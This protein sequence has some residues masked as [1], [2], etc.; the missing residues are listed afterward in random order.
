MAYDLKPFVIN[1]S[2]LLYLLQQVN[3]V[4]LFDGPANSNAI[5]NFDRLSMDAYDAKGN[6]VWDHD[7]QTGSY[8]G[9]PLTAANVGLLGQG[10][11]QVSSPIGIRDVSG[12]HNNLFGD[13]AFWG[14]VD[15][16]FRR[17]ISADFTSYVTTTGADYT[18]GNSVIDY[19]PR[20]IS[21]TITTA[22]VHLLQDSDGHYVNWEA[23]RYASDST[24]A[25][26]ID[27]SAVNPSQLV[28]GAKIVAPLNTDI[29]V[30]DGNGN[31]LVWH[32]SDYQAS[33]VYTTTLAVLAATSYGGLKDSGGGAL[34]EGEAIWYRPIPGGALVSTGQT[35]QPD[36]LAYK[37]LIDAN[38]EFA[39][40]LPPEGTAIVTTVSESG[41]GL[42]ETLGHIDFQNPTS[43][44]FFIGSENP[45]VAPVNSWFGIFGQFFDHGLDLI[46]KGGNGKI[47]I[48]LETTDP[49][50]GMIG[51]DGQPTTS[52]TISRA[53]IAGLDANGDPNYVNHTSPFIDQSQTY[54]SVDQIT[55]LLREW[56]S[57]DDGSTY[58]AGMELFDGTTLV[59][60]WDRR[61]PDG[62]V[63]AVHDTLPTLNELRQHVLDTGRA[64]LNWADVLDYRNRDA[65]GQLADA[66]SDTAGV[67]IS[68][69]GHALILDMN[70]HFDAAH[71]PLAH[72]EAL[73]SALTAA[74]FP[75]FTSTSLS[76]GGL[77]GAGLIN[78]STNLINTNF[79]SYLPAPIGGSAIPKDLQDAVNDVMLDSVGDHYIAG[80]GRVN[81]NFGLTSIHHVFHEEHNYQVEN[82][83]NWIYQHDANNSPLTHDGLR[84]WQVDT[85]TSDAAGNYLN[86]DGSVA[87]DA[88]KMFNATKLLVEMEYQHAAVDQYARTVTPRIQEFVGYST[89]VDST[90][91][92]EYAQVAFRFGHST[93]RE[94]IDTIDPSGWM[95]GNV[96]RYAL[97]KAFLNPQVFA[98]EGVAAITLGLSRQQMSEVDEFITP[99]LNQGLLGQPLDLAAI[100]IAR[101]RDLGIPTLNDF[102]EGISLARYTSWDDFGKNMIH[103]E[104]L[105]NF[106]AAYSFGGDVAK[107]NAILGLFEGTL[108]DGDVAALG[109][110]AADALAFM[111]NNPTTDGGLDAARDGFNHIDS[112][113][114]GLAEAHVPGGLLGETFDAVFVAQI[115]SLMDGDRFYYLYRLFGTN[116]HEEVNNGQFKD[117]V[118]RNTGLS[119]LNGSIFA[120][121]DKYYEF[122]RAA[123]GTLN[124]SG[125]DL[126]EHLYHDT[127]LANPTLGVYSDGGASTDPNGSL[128]SITGSDFVRADVTNSYVRDVRPELDPTQVHTVE[129]TPTSGADSHEVIVATDNADFIHARSGDDTVYGEGGDDFIYGDGGVD[130]LYGGAGNDMIDTGEGPDLADGGAGKDIIYGRGSGSEVGGFDQLV[131]GTGNDLIIGGEGIDKLSGGNGDDIIYGD[132]LTN[133]EMGNTDPFT[134]GGDGNDYIDTGASGDLLYGEEGDDYLVGGIDQDLMQGGTGDDI[135]RPGSPS[136]AIN[137]GPDEVIGDDGFTNTGFDL[138]DFS[139]YAANAPGVVINF[140]TQNNPL[141]AIDGTTPFPAWWQI[142][143]A[144]GSQNNDVF[145]G[146]SSTA[147]A[148][149]DPVNGIT[150]GSNWLIG[151]SGNDTFTGAGGDDLIVGGSVRLDQLIGKYA[152]AIGGN[153]VL[154][155][156]AWLADSMQTTIGGAGYDNNAESAYSGASNRA[157]GALDTSGLLSAANMNSLAHFVEMLRSRMFRDLV[158]GD[159]GTDGGDTV[160]FSGRAS[161]YAI[162]DIVSANGLTGLK[163]ADS[164]LD[165]DGTDLITGVESLSFNTAV[166]ASVVENATLVGAVARLGAVSDT[167][168]YALSGADK[169]LFVV[170]LAGNLQFVLGPDFETPA[171][172]GTNNV[173]N[174]TVSARND[175]NGIAV[176]QGYDVT[177]TDFNEPPQFD[178][179]TTTAFIVNENT[180]QVAAAF[181]ATDP[182]GTNVTFALG[183]AD[184]LLFTINPATGEL[185]F[186][187][188]PDFENG[189]NSYS[190]TII[191]SDGTNLTSLPITVTVADV[192][193]PPTIT[194]S[195]AVSVFEN[196]QDATSVVAS[197]PEGAVVTY[198]ISGGVDAALFS[199]DVTT[200]LI[201]FANPLGADF[202]TPADVG[203]NNTYDIE[204]TVSDGTNTV[205]QPLQIAVTNVNEAPTLVLSSSTVAVNENSQASEVL[206]TATAADPEGTAVAF[207]LTGADA[208]LFNISPT[209]QLT[210]NASPNF[211]Q[212][213]DVGGDNTYD[214]SIVATDAGGLIATRAVS[215]TVNNVNE[216]PSISSPVAIS[217]AENTQLVAAVTGSDPDSATTLA[218]SIIG[219]ADQ[220]KFAINAATGALSFASAAGANFEAP[221]DAGANN[222]YDLVVQVSDGTLVASQTMAVTVIN[223]QEGVS[224]APVISDITP[225]EGQTLSLNTAGIADPDGLGALSYQWQS[226]DGSNW[227]DI[228]GATA[229]AFTPQD[230][231]GAALGFQAGLQLRAVVSYTDG[232]GLLTTINSVATGP[233]GVNWNAIAVLA[234]NFA[235]TAGDDIATGGLG[236]NTLNGG[237]GDDTLVYSVSTLGIVTSGRDTFDGGTNTA[238][239]DRFVLNGTTVAETFRIFTRAAAVAAGLAVPNTATEI[240]ITRNGNFAGA[241]L[242]GA[243]VLAELD[244]IEEITVNTLDVSANDGNGTPNGGASGGDTIAIFGN[245]TAPNTSLN[246]STITINGS[247]AGDTVDISGLTSEH[248]IVFN[249]S[250]AGGNVIGTLRPQD[251]VSE[252]V[253][254]LPP[255]TVINPPPAA[256]TLNG[257]HRND[258]LNGQDGDDT[259]NGNGGND[260][261]H[262]GKGADKVNGGDGQDKVYGDDGNDIINGG[263]GDDRG[264]GGAGDD[265]FKTTRNDGEDAYYGGSAS[266]DAGN[267]TLDMSSILTNISVNL[268]SGSNSKGY[269]QTAGVKDIL[270]GIENFAS[271]SGNDTII[272]STA[273]NVMDGGAGKDTFVFKSAAHA[274][275][276]TISSFEAGDRID[277]SS[278]MGHHVTLVNGPA[279]AGQISVTYETVEGE[280]FTVL[281]GNLDADINDEFALNIKGHHN[282]TGTA[283]A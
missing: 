41:Y 15:V 187:A 139:D 36:V 89:G 148:L 189:V 259:L 159:N 165:R 172:A 141:P 126:A 144:I 201:K 72:L 5:V 82:L 96:T 3:F 245:F 52:I 13:Q 115:Q 268:G 46:G 211:E 121:A 278:F 146:S 182:E 88:D 153:L 110:M 178:F 112:W 53:T 147:L 81:E 4:P 184:A 104:S 27:A 10:F 42:L 103:P 86:S 230:V 166:A 116:I 45:G 269:A 270:Y 181:L 151:G 47:T 249:A 194:S 219:G 158:L 92:L 195:S 67:Q 265:V 70:P 238:I 251:V 277:V 207:S 274:N 109:F 252:G 12:L 9:T 66:D 215:V 2:D 108:A 162:T 208:G 203:Y 190:V 236:N 199:I 97:E 267:D 49:L 174:V 14:A 248:R 56:V 123:D 87:W 19:M 79:P 242:V 234:P 229:A 171:D 218:Y 54:G 168:T 136:Q 61:W 175:L 264:Y 6:Q 243:T 125:D 210:F 200:G 23:A 241:N 275:G 205:I 102:R 105:G 145:V 1:L 16:P 134:H 223:T 50:Y 161:E 106:I 160:I 217:I 255:G 25:A 239:G 94:T 247:N 51:P 244:N 188:P 279:S 167:Y 43:G 222:V 197:D 75:T 84:Q 260:V 122:N 253:T 127:L 117:I 204:V 44:E 7:T 246:F 78:P 266:A 77:I 192:D 227:N 35:Y 119:H 62:T 120:Y 128:I 150:D 196:V 221:T 202:E 177:V 271:G 68:G 261:L 216:G 71:V 156:A 107:A 21:R 55:N 74:G 164:V 29:S 173:Y 140:A 258:A 98:E 235:G 90:V 226:F 280:E 273:H 232:A 225:T 206:V 163:I 198:L 283:L 93:I 33:V 85:G 28:E 131:G 11:P 132:G 76:Y 129:G 250:A 214:L 257:N 170:D 263:R 256:L 143:G 138:I 135:L 281:H 58:H 157:D 169:D 111:L 133:P 193:E 48:A 142:E 60:A 34:E 124:G 262:G 180:V 83:K 73:N 176:I 114:G 183:G 30:L 32:L 154:G 8:Q 99:A 186:V 231:A 31:P 100:N 91:S 101:G 209:G 63:E 20:I 254:V 40:G 24:Y 39:S 152:G 224:G 149:T 37:Q 26:L 57:T 276:D 237:A 59:D 22:D 80:D 95:L 185:N 272:A 179:G 228:G 130:R 118:E 155:S 220:G 69:S 137:G 240:V 191:A 64:A 233:T 17:D 38:V 212:P 65:N 213:L 113:I 18:P 282:L